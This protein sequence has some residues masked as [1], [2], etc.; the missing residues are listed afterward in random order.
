MGNIK[1]INDLLKK[2]EMNIRDEKDKKE[3]LV[4]LTSIRILVNQFKDGN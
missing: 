4:L 2:L 3:Q 1:A